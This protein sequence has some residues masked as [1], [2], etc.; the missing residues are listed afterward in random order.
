MV[1]LLA[2]A[3]RMEA[4]APRPRAREHFAASVGQPP[5]ITAPD[6]TFAI[7]FASARCEHYVHDAGLLA[8]TPTWTEPNRHLPNKRPHPELGTIAGKHALANALTCVRG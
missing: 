2:T 7:L 6:S 1:L 4:V 5:L 3:T 8:S